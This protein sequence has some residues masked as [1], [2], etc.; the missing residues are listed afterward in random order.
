MPGHSLETTTV[1]VSNRVE[2][3]AV[4]KTTQSLNQQY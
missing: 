3:G 1:N 4:T 2:R